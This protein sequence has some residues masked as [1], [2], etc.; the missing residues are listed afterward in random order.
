MNI[1][2]PLKTLLD[3]VRDISPSTSKSSPAHKLVWTWVQTSLTRNLMAKAG[4]F[5]TSLGV[6][7]GRNNAMLSA[8]PSSLLEAMVNISAIRVTAMLRGGKRAKRVV[9][10]QQE[11]KGEKLYCLHAGSC[12]ALFDN[13]EDLLLHLSDVLRSFPT[14]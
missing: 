1:A 10:V 3:V 9:E 8:A 4:R 11:K 14:L 5:K 13:F 2:I 12:S 7:S 6:G